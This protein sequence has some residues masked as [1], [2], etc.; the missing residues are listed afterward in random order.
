MFK[1][2][3]SWAPA[4][5]TPIGTISDLLA[6]ART[7]LASG[8]AP[9]GGRVLSAESTSRMQTVSHDMGTPN[10]PPIG[11]GWL[12]MP[13][14]ATTVLSMSGA[15]PGGVAV[16]AVVPEHDFAFAAF[17][18]D[19]RAMQLHDQLLLSLLHDHA[20]RRS[21]RNWAPTSTGRGDLRRYAGTYRSNQ[22][23]VD[24]RVV[25]GELEETMTYEPLDDQ[26]ARIFAGFAGA[27]VPAAAATLRARGPEPVR[28][29]RD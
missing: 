13:F 6:F 10:V 15:S 4:G 2:P 29:G 14:G 21:R 18:N 1:L 24:V 26:Q 17:G 28:A 5:S 27:T 22:L 3:D 23:R 9:S 25:D 11:Y 12:L 16:L 8:L 7:H 20:R 19:P